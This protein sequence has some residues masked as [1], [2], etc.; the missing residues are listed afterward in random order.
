MENCFTNGGSHSFIGHSR[1]RVCLTWDGFDALHLPYEML[2][3]SKASLI[4]GTYVTRAN[5]LIQ[6]VKLILG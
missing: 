3:S 5:T 2:F 6:A 1:W 4:A